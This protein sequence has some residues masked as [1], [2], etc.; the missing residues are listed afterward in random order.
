MLYNDFDLEAGDGITV[1]IQT[2]NYAGFSEL[3]MGTGIF[4]PSSYIPPAVETTEFDETLD[5]PIDVNDDYS[6]RAG[7]SLT[8]EWTQP[9]AVEN[10]VSYSIRV[11]DQ[12]GTVTTLETD[13]DP[14]LDRQ[15][16]VV[17]DLEVNIRYTFTVTA[18]SD[19]GQ[20]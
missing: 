20:S 19:A 11:T 8:L 5:R 10:I 1:Q 12:D 17:D 4:M 9:G 6:N 3:T 16:V 14:I 2:K 15:F 18:V 7:Q 13:F